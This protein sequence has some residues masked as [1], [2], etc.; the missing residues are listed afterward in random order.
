[1]T[2]S[3]QVT[4]CDHKAIHD[5]KVT[6]LSIIKYVYSLSLLVFSTIMIMGVIFNESTKLSADVSPWLALIVFWAAIVWLTM[7]EGQQASLV[8]LPPIDFE[9]Y[10]DTHPA[11]YQNTSLALKGDNLNRYLMGRQFMVLLVVFVINMCGA[12]L[13]GAEVLG[14]PDIVIQIFLGTGIAMILVT[15]MIGQLATQVD[16]SHCMLDYINNRFAL[17]TLYTA[18]AIEFTGVMHS[19]YLI[20]YILAAVSGKPIQSK[21]EPKSVFQLVFF[22]GRVLMSLAILGFSLA[23]TFAAIFQGK[24]TMWDGVPEIVSLVLFVVLMCVVGMLEGMQIAFF[25]VAKLPAA[26]RGNGFFAKKTCDLLFT[27]NGQNLPG[28]M[29]GRQLCVVACFFI[30]ARVTT[31]NV[32]V[33]TG[34]NIFGVGDGVQEFLNTGLHAAVIT[35]ILASITWQ[36]AASAFPLA[37]L[38]SPFTYVLLVIA[39]TLEATGVC[40][41]AWALARV[42]KRVM[43]LQYDEVYV[44]TP[45]ERVESN[46]ADKARTAGQ[47]FG[48]PVGDGQI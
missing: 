27:G 16:A 41:G 38:A 4:P 3:A 34:E 26:E 21:E 8:G 28:F 12:P 14:L 24:T 2:Q 31:L 18:M 10:K 15:C 35:T 32:E 1:M 46:K 6:L 42:V 33:G 29:I 40:A 45:E 30:I 17:F 13:A 47:V 36:L 23:V 22:W 25:A 44:G 39:L 7:I 48:A 5:E 37:F 11:T 43:G 19:S 20:E 9:L